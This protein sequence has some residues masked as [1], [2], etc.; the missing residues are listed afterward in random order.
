[1]YNSHPIRK[2]VQR[3]WYLPA[4]KPN[5]MYN[6][7]AEGIRNYAGVPDP[8]ILGLIKDQL[9]WFDKTA[10]LA[11]ATKA[12]CDDIVLR[13]NIIYNL[14]KILPGLDQPHTQLY[15]ILRVELCQIEEAGGIIE[16]LQPPTGALSTIKEMVEK[17]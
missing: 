2:Q 16:E 3:E 1:M 17:F 4:G 13:S 15:R 10:Y 14:T 11:P 6:Y 12:L 9:S 8:S 5:I 7:P